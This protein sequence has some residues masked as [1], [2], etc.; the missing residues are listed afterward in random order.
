MTPEGVVV[1]E[2][3]GTISHFFGMCAEKLV[4][5]FPTV[6]SEISLWDMFMS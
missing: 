1:A 4:S 3:E 5:C 2:K 6:Y